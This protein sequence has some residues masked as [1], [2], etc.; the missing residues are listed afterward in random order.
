[1]IDR[2]DADIRETWDL[3]L[4]F[5]DEEAYEKLLRETIEKVDRFAEKY[6]SNIRDT[7]DIKEALEEYRQI[8]ECLS[9][10]GNYCSLDV[11]ANVFNKEAV[12][13]QANFSKKAAQIYSKLSFLETD[14]C[15]L[16]LDIL[17][18]AAKNEEDRVYL[19]KIMKDKEHILS[20]DVEK[21]LAALKNTIYFPYTSY[22]DIKFRDIKF[23]DFEVNGKT[24]HMTYNSFEGRLE[25][26]LDK[27]LRREAFRV[28]SDELRKYENSTASAYNA[29]VQA[30]KTIS[31]LRGYDSV[32]DYLL[33]MQD[34]S[35][36]LYNRQLDVI[37]EDLA[38]H[39][40]KYAKLIGDIYGLDKVK[41]E[42]LKLEIDPNYSPK[43]SFEE[44]KK[45]ILD[46]LSLLGGD[47][48]K[49]LEEAFDKRWI[50]Y[51]ETTGKR[52]GAFCASPYGA[53]SFILM[54]FSES[55]SDCMTLA[56][57]LGHAGHFQLAHANQ[58]ILN[59]RPS[60]Y[61]VEAPS[62]TNELLLENYLLDEA[63]DDLTM[64]R[65][66]ISQMIS[67]TY[68]H[69]FV[70]HFIEG[71]FQREVYRLVDK[72]E[73]LDA[74]KLDELF[75]D[76][77]EKFWADSVE[78][79]QGAEL[80]WMRQPHY[81]MGLYPYTYSAGLTIGTQMAMKIRSQGQEVADNWIRVL[82]MGGTKNAEGL[83]K[84][85]LVDISTDQPLKDT[86]AY[87]GS[88]VEELVD[89]TGKLK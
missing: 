36:D 63:K 45:Y 84:E 89:L 25:T 49:I 21:A 20:K 3:T 31:L 53:N 42:D 54:F 29:Q 71:Y 81:Y 12:A 86:V 2:K 88:L 44:A 27:D 16:D 56:H 9:R 66:V 77:L 72:G 33:D 1:M 30:E 8:L 60:M 73:S 5:K 61:F 19:E 80:T 7:N 62:T 26:D 58:N 70:T 87:I 48:K 75:R 79:T 82:K 78:L 76:T 55:M 67:K 10:M 18:Q 59:S 35:A 85:A 28:F 43:V 37:M 51:A 4:L 41:Y 52:T 57:E 32:F 64:R 40:R 14:L 69:N 39:M 13:R 38:P 34:V 68:Y 65:W 50:D 22:N 24:H 83:A 74:D 17:E 47:Y 23:P 6:E 11:E 15:Q 46:G